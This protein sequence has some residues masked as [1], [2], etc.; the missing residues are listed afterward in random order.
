MR[1]GIMLCAYGIVQ[2]DPVSLLYFS[3]VVSSS[4][5]AFLCREYGKVC[6]DASWPRWS[7]IS[8]RMECRFENGSQCEQR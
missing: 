8:A 5:R 3:G 1:V 4:F 2:E 6:S 7:C